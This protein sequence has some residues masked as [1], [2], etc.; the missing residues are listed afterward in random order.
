MKSVV[1]VHRVGK[2]HDVS[3]TALLIENAWAHLHSLAQ[4]GG[5]KEI[6]GN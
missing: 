3:S 6:K 2:Q 1:Q 4:R 5:T